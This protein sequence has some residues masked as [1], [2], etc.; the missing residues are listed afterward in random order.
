MRD[1]EGVIK[2]SIKLF[3]KGARAIERVFHGFFD[4]DKDGI[5]EGLQNMNTIRGRENSNFRRTLQEIRNIIRQSLYY[6]SE[7]EPIDSA[8]EK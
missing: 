7:L 8:S 5:H 2:D 1:T 3:G 4:E 6:I